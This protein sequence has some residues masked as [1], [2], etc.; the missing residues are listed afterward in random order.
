MSAHAF[1]NASTADLWDALSAASGTDMRVILASWTEQAGFPLITVTSSC[2]AAGARTLR[3]SQQRFLLAGTAPSEARWSVPLQI[4]SGIAAP[5]RSVLLTQ[6]EQSIDAGRCDEALSVNADAVGF[7]RARYDSTILAAETA[8]FDRVPAGDRI[9]LLD[10]QW[11]LAQAG[12][13]PLSTYLRLVAAMGANL[14]GRAWEQI[15]GALESIEYDERGR[16]GH[17]AFARY[18]RAVIGPVFARLGWDAR[19]GESADTQHLRRVL[20]ADLGEWGEP[21]IIDETRRRFRAFVRSRKAISPD[22]QPSV[23]GVVARYADA[24]TFEQLHA[25]A[26]SSRNEAEVRRFYGALVA[27]EDPELAAQAAAIAL[28]SEIPPQAG[29]LRLGLVVRIG[30]DHPTLSWSAFTRNAA[31]LLSP[32]ARYVP[33]ISAQQVPAW[34]W[35]G[36]PISEIESWVRAQVPAEMAPN[37]ERGLQTARFR[38]AERERLLPAADAFVSAD[39][40]VNVRSESRSVRRDSC[41]EF[42]ARSASAPAHVSG[43]V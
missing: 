36:V 12:S 10:D 28:S 5:A 15:A 6:T 29:S 2:D 7:Y 18:A 30:T 9:A 22:D 3:L 16:P 19:P 17:E 23:L 38:L 35:N 43:R 33:L 14:D 41:C 42:H 24:A 1:S 39:T 20:L 21:S 26:R 11:A 34:Y 31:T 40:A 8:A 27:V 32:F 37:I 13:E 25:I 4:R